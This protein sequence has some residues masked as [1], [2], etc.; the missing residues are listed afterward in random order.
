M[1]PLSFLYLC[2][3]NTYSDMTGY[4]QAPVEVTGLSSGVSSISVGGWHACAL[5]N[6]GGV[7]CWGSNE[8]GSLGNGTFT[9]DFPYGMP[10]PVDVIFQ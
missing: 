7:K 8:L 6:S 5:M 2:L 1:M 4:S 10:T 3:M 9:Q